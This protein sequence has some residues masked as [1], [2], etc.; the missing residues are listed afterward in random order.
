MDAGLPSKSQLIEVSNGIMEPSKRILRYLCSRG[1]SAQWLLM[2]QGPV[3][4][5]DRD[6]TD[7]DRRM[8]LKRL[9]SELKELT[10]FSGRL[11]ELQ[12]ILARL[13]AQN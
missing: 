1:F 12:M 10:E 3:L 7:K 13:K 2:G 8:L 5:M 9:K 4:W 6:M 11:L